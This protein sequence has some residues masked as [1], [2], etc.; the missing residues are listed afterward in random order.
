MQRPRAATAVPRLVNRSA[1]WAGRGL[2]D[3]VNAPEVFAAR[4]KL[5]GHAWDAEG[6]GAGVV[7]R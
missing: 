3:T 6:P 2:K 7:Q 4:K 1:G 5:D